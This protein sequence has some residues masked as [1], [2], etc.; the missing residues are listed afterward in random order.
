MLQELLPAIIPSWRF[1]D[2][3][4]PAPRLECALVAAANDP[5]LE[6]REVSP[7]PARVQPWLAFAHLFWNPYGNE[8][9][10]LV[11]CAERLIETPT[12]ARADD[13]WHRVA[14]IVERRV[15]Q[16]PAPPF[17]RIRIVQAMRERNAVVDHVAWTSSAQRWSLAA[18]RTTS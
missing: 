18:R 1:F 17:L 2:R 9:L 16:T 6:W 4:G 15:G 10:F 8:A 12:A 13:L 3:I 7:R 14:E 11:S 5:P